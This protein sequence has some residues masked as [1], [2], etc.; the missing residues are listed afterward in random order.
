MKRLAA[1]TTGI[2]YFLTSAY[3]YAA[4]QTIQLAPPQGAAAGIAPS[5]PVGTVVRNA[6]TIVFIVAAVLVLFF[7]VIGAFQWI[8]SGGD[9]EK[10]GNARKTILNALV[11]FAILALAFLIARVVGLV[12]NIDLLGQLVIP[13]LDKQ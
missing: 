5:T 9:K 6:L 1:L 8:T 10:V 3:I 13:S 4:D 11:G 7:L 12:V 2:G